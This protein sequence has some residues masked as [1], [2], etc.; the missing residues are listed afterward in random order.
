MMGVEPSRPPPGSAAETSCPHARIELLRRTVRPEAQLTGP[1]EK[2][3][4]GQRDPLQFQKCSASAQHDPKLRSILGFHATAG[5]QVMPSC[6]RSRLNG[7][8]SN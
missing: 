5:L 3:R 8:A 6:N 2:S 7:C 4:L 1:H